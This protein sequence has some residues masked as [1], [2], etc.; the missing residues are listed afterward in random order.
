MTAPKIKHIKPLGVQFDPSG[1]VG[2]EIE[3][4]YSDGT[5][6]TLLAQPVAAILREH[7]FEKE[8]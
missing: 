6:G 2:I 7:G 3:V 5:R 8:D 1:E 4:R